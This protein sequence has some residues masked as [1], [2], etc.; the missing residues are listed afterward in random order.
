MPPQERT[1]QIHLGIR[2]NDLLQGPGF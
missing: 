2:D 1:F